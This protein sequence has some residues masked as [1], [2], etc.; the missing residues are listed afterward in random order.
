MRVWELKNFLDCVQRWRD[1][2]A[3]GDQ[4]VRQFLEWT[5]TR[6]KRD[7]FVVGARPMVFNE[8]ASIGDPEID[9]DD[10]DPDD[11]IPPATPMAMFEIVLPI[12]TDNGCQ[13]FCAYAV[14]SRAGE[15]ICLLLNEIK[16][17]SGER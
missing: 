4:S 13:V 14:N 6:L 5:V 1:A 2:E 7:P 9:D 12:V 17:S 15:I 8:Y 11:W 16:D 10:V 3:P